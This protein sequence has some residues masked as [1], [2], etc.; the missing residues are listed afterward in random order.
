MLVSSLIIFQGC[1]SRIGC[2]RC[3]SNSRILSHFQVH[4]HGRKIILGASC[5]RHII[6][7]LFIANDSPVE[8]SHGKIRIQFDHLRIIFKRFGKVLYKHKIQSTSEIGIRIFR[9]L[10]YPGREIIDGCEMY[11][12]LIFR[13]GSFLVC[14][15]QFTFQ[16]QAGIIGFHHLV[17]INQFLYRIY[18]FVIGQD[19]HR[20]QVYTHIAILY[21]STN[22]AI[23]LRLA[24]LFF[25]IYD[26]AVK[27]IDIFIRLFTCIFI[28]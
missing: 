12:N 23:I 14:D 3:T 22:F 28:L 10:C 9:I 5:L 19:K 13:K 4:T 7:K 16:Y 8:I 21:A 25:I 26:K 20:F 11:G 17:I 6:V 1:R 15:T 18:F 24:H 27:L 2:H